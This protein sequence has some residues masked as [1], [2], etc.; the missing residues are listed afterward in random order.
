MRRLKRGCAAAA[1]LRNVP[2]D[3][4]AHCQNAC[5]RSAKICV[6]II[7]NPDRTLDYDRI[8]RRFPRLS[9]TLAATKIEAN[10]F[11]YQRQTPRISP[12]LQH[13]SS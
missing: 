6:R 12:R 2:P 13:G 8:I 5:I 7:L 4:D 11:W 1:H 10:W 3:R 9:E